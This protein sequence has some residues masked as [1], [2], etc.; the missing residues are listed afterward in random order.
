[1]L[2]FPDKARACECSGFFVLT[3]VIFA[4]TQLITKNC[5]DPQFRIRLEPIL[6]RAI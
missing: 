5:S 1:M 3:G 4:E 2:A 6:N